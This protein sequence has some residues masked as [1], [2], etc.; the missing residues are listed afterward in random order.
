[1]QF[2]SEFAG[3]GAATPTRQP[4]EPGARPAETAAVAPLPQLDFSIVAWFLIL[5]FALGIYRWVLEWLG[6]SE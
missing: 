5:V 2:I 3:A 6:L 1:M 4:P